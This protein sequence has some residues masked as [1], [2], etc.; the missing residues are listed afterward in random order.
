MDCA[1]GSPSGVWL[2]LPDI[3]SAMPSGEGEVARCLNR[4]SSISSADGRFSIEALLILEKTEV[5]GLFGPVILPWLDIVLILFKNR[6]STIDSESSKE[7]ALRRRVP[8]AIEEQN[9]Q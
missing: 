7:D 6:L 9:N 4:F 8:Q 5:S 2:E 1:V 3:D